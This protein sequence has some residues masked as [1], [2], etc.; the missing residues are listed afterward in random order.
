MNEEDAWLS[1]TKWWLSAITTLMP[2]LLVFGALAAAVGVVAETDVGGVSGRY[3]IIIQGAL[4]WPPYVPITLA[5]FVVS[6][7]LGCRL[8]VPTFAGIQ[9]R[10][11]AIVM[12]TWPLALGSALIWRDVLGV[13]FFTAIGVI[14]ALT[15]PLPKKSLLAGASIKDAA[16]VGLAMSALV[17]VQ[18][19]LVAIMWCAWRLYKNKSV[20]VAVTAA[21]AA[22]MPI[23]LILTELR[24]PSQATI[25]SGFVVEVALLLG[26]ILAGFFFWK[27]P[28]PVREIEEDEYEEYEEYEA[29]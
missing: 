8:L 24:D 20:E 1:E 18:G 13:V 2:I 9:P 3:D 21:C 7:L 19:T 25:T 11:V 23:L 22:L 28:R 6:A 14:W 15:M 27:F 10:P 26:L 12:A 16:V 17:L 29:E 5:P 4:T